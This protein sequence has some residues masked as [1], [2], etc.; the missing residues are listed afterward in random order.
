MIGNP[1]KQADRLAV[2][3]LAVHYGLVTQSFDVE[4]ARYVSAIKKPVNTVGRCFLDLPGL[5]CCIFCLCLF[6][7]FACFCVVF[8][9]FCVPCSFMVLALFVFVWFVSYAFLVPL[10]LLAFAGWFVCCS[11]ILV[12]L[13]DTWRSARKHDLM[14]FIALH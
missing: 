6:A 3:E 4:P 11:L 10:C 1:S 13:L 14:Q 7:V 5:V 8:A 9:W 12:A 2:H